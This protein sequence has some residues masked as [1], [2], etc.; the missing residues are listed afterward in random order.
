MIS[1]VKS[2]IRHNTVNTGIGHLTDVDRGVICLP[3]ICGTDYFVGWVKIFMEIYPQL[4]NHIVALTCG[5]APTYFLGKAI[6]S[7]I[8]E[9]LTI[10]LIC[11]RLP[12]ANDWTISYDLTRASYSKLAVLPTLY[13]AHSPVPANS[14]NIITLPN[15]ADEFKK[16]SLSWD[17]YLVHICE[18]FDTFNVLTEATE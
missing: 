11:D 13:C 6:V 17:A 18:Y 1:Y 5:K 15:E 14:E 7:T 3:H 2:Y 10:A 4:S 12:V 16:R 8:N 9:Q